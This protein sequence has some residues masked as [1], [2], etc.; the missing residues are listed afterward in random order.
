MQE[1]LIIVFSIKHIPCFKML[2][3]IKQWNKN[4]IF[5]LSEEQYSYSITKK[6][7][8]NHGFNTSIPKVSGLVNVKR[9]K[10][11]NLHLIEKKENNTYPTKVSKYT[12]Y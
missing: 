6:R 5:A 4:Y 1:S 8:E 3:E 2:R 7:S 10:S 11:Q 9:M 12:C